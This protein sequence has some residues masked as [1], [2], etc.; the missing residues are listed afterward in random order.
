MLTVFLME[1]LKKI[2]LFVEFLFLLILDK[3]NGV[4]KG[5][6]RMIP[7]FYWDVSILYL[8]FLGSIS[9]STIWF[10]LNI[11]IAGAYVYC[12]LIKKQ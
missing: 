12:G 2:H 9:A 5:Y 3:L 10:D 11:V 7:A 4:G 6:T 1:T 8:Y